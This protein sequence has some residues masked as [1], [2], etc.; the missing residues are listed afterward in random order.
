MPLSMKPLLSFLP[1]LLALFLTGYLR[2]EIKVLSVT[3]TSAPTQCNGALEI[4][5]TGNA[6]PFT[7]TWKKDG[8]DYTPSTPNATQM[9]GLCSGQYQ[10]MIFNKFQ[11]LIKILVVRK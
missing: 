8:A 3:P 1:C 7:I 10:A 5:V 2:A 4:V 9:S 6:E 11:C